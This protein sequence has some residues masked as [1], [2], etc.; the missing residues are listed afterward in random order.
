MPFLLN[1]YLYMYVA[2]TGK[3]YKIIRCCGNMRLDSDSEADSERLVRDSNRADV[4][5]GQ[6]VC[7]DKSRQ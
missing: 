2:Y 1:E 6:S 3:L 4:H 7:D 5:G